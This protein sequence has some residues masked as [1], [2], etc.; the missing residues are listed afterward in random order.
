MSSLSTVPLSALRISSCHWYVSS[1]Q[2]S[3]MMPFFAKAL[4][5][6]K[7]NLP[8]TALFTLIVM[9]SRSASTRISKRSPTRIVGSRT[10]NSISLLICMPDGKT[11]QVVAL[12]TVWDQNL[13][14]D[15]TL[16]LHMVLRPHWQFHNKDQVECGG[17]L[18]WMAISASDR[19]GRSWMWKMSMWKILRVIRLLK[20]VVPAG[21]GWATPVWW[22]QRSEW[23]SIVS[24]DS[25]SLWDKLLTYKQSH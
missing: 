9:V 15:D 13:Q 7:Q 24:D 17:H 16:T 12:P 5:A 18:H 11:S 8:H 20:V 10:S 1:I 22:C 6:W 3:L 14:Y 23:D 4:R 19:S 2:S 25:V 21:W